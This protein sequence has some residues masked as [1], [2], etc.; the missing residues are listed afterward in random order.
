MEKLASNKIS[1]EEAERLLK[2]LKRSIESQIDFP[3]KGNDTEFEVVGQNSKD[4]FA[5]NIYRGNINRLKYNIGA[6]IVKNGVLLLELH[7][8]PSNVHANP[9]GKKIAGSHWHIYSEEY[10]R[11][12]AFPA[13]N[14]I[15]ENFI[16]NTIMFLD[17]FNVIEKPNIS[18]QPELI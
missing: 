18:F 8:N 12:V 7:I 5:V 1:Q 3:L 10:G 11:T 6:R 17:K 9:D 13:E 15:S 16:E 4:L 14:I 2:M